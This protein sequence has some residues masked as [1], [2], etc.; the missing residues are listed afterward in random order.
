[1]SKPI[2]WNYCLIYRAQHVAPLQKRS[3]GIDGVIPNL[4]RLPAKSIEVNHV[5][6]R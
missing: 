3:L 5:Q 4:L 2:P 6:A 1:M